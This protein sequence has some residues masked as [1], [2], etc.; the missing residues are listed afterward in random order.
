MSTAGAI[1]GPLDWGQVQYFLAVAEGGSIQ[2]AA[3]RLSVNHS[4][5]LRRIAALERQ[6]GCRLFDRL[7]GGYAL[8][9]AGNNLAEHLGGLTEQF[10]SAER[11]VRGLDAA[12]RGP[13]RVTSSDVV[14]EGLL[15]P[16]LAQFRRRHPQVQVQLVMKYSFATL[17]K[18]EADIAVRGADE[19]PPNLVAC[20][21]GHVESVLCASPL[22]L[23]SIDGEQPVAARRWVIVD[24]SLSF[25]MF[26]NWFREHVAPERVAVRVD[27]LVGVADAVAHGLGIGFLPRP[28]VAARPGLVQ[29]GPPEPSLQKPIWVLMHPDVQHT[30]RVRALYQFLV[31]ALLAD[32]NLAH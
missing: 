29:L 8:T 22:Y 12:L 5:V 26:D 24:E 2:S 19:A 14:V 9:S 16:L 28:L 6:L 20:R 4:T 32:L 11:Q 25:G 10:E 13:V 15:M 21:V 1:P 30:A 23:Q 17:S 3:R 31:E 18:S 7:P 27:S